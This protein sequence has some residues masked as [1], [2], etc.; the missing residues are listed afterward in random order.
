MG[1]TLTMNTTAR[2]AARIL[3]MVCVLLAPLAAQQ[4]TPQVQPPKQMPGYIIGQND[5]LRVTVYSGG[6]SQPDFRLT[7]FT[8]QTDGSVAL[9]LIKPIKIAGLSVTAANEAVRK[10]LLDTHQ[11]SECIVDIVV[12]GYHS[13]H[14]KVQGAVNKP[15]NIDMTAE[16]MNIS[17]ALNAA[18]NLQPS[19]GSE[20][21]VKRAGSRAAEPDVLVRDG[22]EIYSRE[23]LNN[24]KLTDVQLYNDDTIDV[25]VAPKFYV[26][27]FVTTPGESQWEPNLTLERAL[28]KVGGATKDGA[29]NRVEVRRM[30]PKTK[31]YKKIKLAKDKMSTIIE[32][33]DIINV[34]KRRM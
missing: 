24:G 3:A 28:L 34:P 4:T 7:D 17:D 2:S 6:Q 23:D 18:G 13:S 29:L 12:M 19:A 5:V 15:G 1:M 25:P 11:F 8:V 30:D 10:A 27:G 22:W 31:E 16:K 33:G 14:L 21:R 26:Q 32:A 9:P 20:I